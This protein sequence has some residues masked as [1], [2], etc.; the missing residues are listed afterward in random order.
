MAAGTTLPNGKPAGERGATPKRRLRRFSQVL[1]V[2]C[3]F[4]AVLTI[5]DLARSASA[6]A[7]L[8]FTPNHNF[9]AQGQYLPAK[10]GF[11]LA[12]I[13]SVEQLDALPPGVMGL[14]WVGL[15]NGADPAFVRT[16]TPYVGN[17]RLFGFYLMDDPDP[18]WSATARGDAHG[19]R[20][21]NLKAESDWIHAHV[22]GGLTFIVVMNLGPAAR[23]S[24]EG[25]YNPENSH[26][27][28]FGIDPYPCRSELAGC[29]FAMIDR[30]VAAAARWGIPRLSMVPVFQTFG[31]GAWEDGDGG[32]YVPPDGDQMQ[33][34]LA[35]WGALL[36]APSFDYAYSWGAQRGDSALE[37]SVDLM[38]VL[39]AHNRA[40]GGP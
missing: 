9:D 20:P 37:D 13:S 29:D 32:H 10:A 38:A 15:C 2:L 8:H 21:E 40:N 19:C 23:P 35:R 3:C 7:P 30:Y 24:F 31:G 28:L 18:R 34:M 5:H 1:S 4:G 36:P 39:S 33:T 11:N 16:I 27:D 17:S 12:D 6:N 14:V 26:I 25:S 22:P